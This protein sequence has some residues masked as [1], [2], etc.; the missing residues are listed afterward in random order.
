MSRTTIN[1]VTLCSYKILNP[2][3]VSKQ[4]DP[5][6]CAELI[7]D[8]SGLDSDLFR[9]G[10]TK[11]CFNLIS[12]HV[13]HVFEFLFIL[14]T[15]Q[16]M[17]GLYKIHVYVQTK[18]DLINKFLLVALLILFCFLSSFYL[19]FFYNALCG[20]QIQNSGRQRCER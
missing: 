13:C 3:A 12:Y 16:W 1:L 4:P 20:I 7:L 10:H 17:Y 14:A 8:A 5:K 2:T 19:F 18:V 6:K 9:L 11:A 15:I